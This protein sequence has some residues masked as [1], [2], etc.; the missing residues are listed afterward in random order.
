VNQNGK[1]WVTEEVDYARSIGK[2]TGL[3]MKTD[4]WFCGVLTFEEMNKQSVSFF[5]SMDF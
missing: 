3:L 1:N 2:P 4:P 5:L